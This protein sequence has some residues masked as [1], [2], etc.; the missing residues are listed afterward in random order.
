MSA[1][2]ESPLWIS[3]F[4]VVSTP[5]DAM[6]PSRAEIAQ[7]VLAVFTRFVTSSIP[8]AQRPEP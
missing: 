8:K 6:A 7:D 4:E 2:V 3:E 5:M 1:T